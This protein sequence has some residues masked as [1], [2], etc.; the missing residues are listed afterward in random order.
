MECTKKKYNILWFCTDQ[1]RFDTLGAYGNKFV[2]TPHID[3]LAQNGVKFA[4]AYSQSPVCT[5]SRASFLTGRYPSTT[6]C[7]QNGQKIPDH[8]IL[9]TKRLRDAGYTCGLAGKLHLAPCDTAA[10]RDIEERIDDGYTIFHWSH[11]SHNN[12][13]WPTHEYRLWAK[14]KGCEWHTTPV[15]GTKW[16]ETGPDEEF[17]QTTWC[18]EKA[19]E[20][21]KAHEHSDTPWLFSVN[22]YDPHHPFDPPKKYLDRY[23]DRLGEIPLPAYQKGELRNKPIYQQRDHCGAYNDKNNYAY[24]EMSNTDHKLVKAA[25]YAMVDLIDVQFGRIMDA[26]KQTG[27][28]EHTIVIFMSD[29]GELLGD[30]GMYLKGPHFYESAVKVPLILSC[31]GTIVEGKT[32]DGL[33]ELV[34]LAPTLLEATGLTKHEGMQGISFWNSVTAPQ[35]NEEYQ[36][37]S[38]YCEFYNAMTNHNDPAAFATMVRNHRY[39]MVEYHGTEY[40]ELYDLQADPNEYNNVWDDKNHTQA[41][42]EMYKVLSTRMANCVDPLPVRTAPY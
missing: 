31:P 29:H 38:V 17:H 18:A 22:P 7:R 2:N 36:R 19:I 6:R 26:L 11:H 42:L 32:I 10:C 35:D 12:P 9:I 5:P 27:Q 13:D 25:Y 4:N 28:L 23:I 20:F 41:K 34:D 3:A 16:V 37:E 8:E 39:K 21:I 40:G 15:E 33:T 24:D 14:E 30:H 1:Q